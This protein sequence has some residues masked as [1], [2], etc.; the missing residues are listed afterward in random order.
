MFLQYKLTILV[1][2]IHLISNCAWLLYHK[3]IPLCIVYDIT[4]HISGFHSCVWAFYPNLYTVF[5]ICNFCSFCKNRSSRWGPL[6]LLFDSFSLTRRIFQSF[7]I[8]AVFAKITVLVRALSTPSSTGFYWLDDFPIFRRLYNNC[9]SRSFRKNRRLVGAL[10]DRF[11][12]TQRFFQFFAD[13]TIIAIF[14]VFAE[15]ADRVVGRG[16]LWQVYI[17]S[18]AACKPGHISPRLGLGHW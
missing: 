8:F 13:F 1:M 7:A 5:S 4:C 11:T 2:I 6:N 14:A 12:S 15:I 16:H 9:N 3:M 10:F 18:T 17:D